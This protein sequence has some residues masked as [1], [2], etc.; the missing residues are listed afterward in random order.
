LAAELDRVLQRGQTEILQQL[1]QAN[2]ILAQ[3]VS[4]ID[5]LSGIVQILAPRAE[6]SEQAISILEQLQ[7][8]GYPEIE[9]RKFSG[10]F[11]LM[12]FGFGSTGPEITTSEPLF[13]E[14]DLNKLADYDLLRPRMSSGG[15]AFYGITRA[16][17]QFLSQVRP[18]PPG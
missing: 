11:R 10:G 5:G 2:S 8:S 7:T 15:T 12:A 13:A 14:D 3:L 1:S 9:L 17:T 18:K 6:F 4:R 16:A